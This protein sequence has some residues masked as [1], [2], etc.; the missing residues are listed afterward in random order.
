MPRQAEIVLGFCLDNLA[1]TVPERSLLREIAANLHRL[2][3]WGA[4]NPDKMDPTRA[5][6]ARCKELL[7]VS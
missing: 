4:E 5:L 2:P 3:A 6:F 1:L 7:G